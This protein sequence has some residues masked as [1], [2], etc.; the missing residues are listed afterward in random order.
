MKIVV[1]GA[2]G[3]LG[4]AMLSA[5]STRHAAVGLRRQDVDI[6]DSAALTQTLL[7]A[8]PDAI[9]NCA[10]F[11][12]VDPAEDAPAQALAVNAIAVRTLARVATTLDATL[13]HYSTDFVFDGDQAGPN[14][15]DRDPHPSGVYASSKLIGEWFARATR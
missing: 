8:Q 3:Q 10:A 14:T 6:T 15:E 13:V 9:I 5:A 12:Q 11:S 1:L 4:G 7:A 2:A